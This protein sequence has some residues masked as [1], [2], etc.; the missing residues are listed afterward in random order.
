MFRY[1]PER[2]IHTS[3]AATFVSLTPP[4]A[5]LASL[6]VLPAEAELR[7]KRRLRFVQL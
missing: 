6:S 1:T 3:L 7:A 4:L 5:L 2:D